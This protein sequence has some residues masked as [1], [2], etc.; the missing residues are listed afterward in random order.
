MAASSSADSNQIESR[1]EAGFEHSHSGI[2]DR[3]SAWDDVVNKLGIRKADLIKESKIDGGRRTYLFEGRVYKIV[4]L[5]LEETRQKRLLS[6][7][8]EQKI[9]EKLS[10][11]M[12]VPQNPVYKSGDCFECLIYDYIEG[13][14]LSEIKASFYRKL[15]LLK[16]IAAITAKF[17][18]KGIAHNDI[19]LSNILVD[20]SDCVSIVDFDQATEISAYIAW[21]VNFTGAGMGMRKSFGTV[22]SIIVELAKP[23]I[24]ENVPDPVIEILRKVM[25]S[26]NRFKQNKR[27]PSINQKAD[28]K[29][30][31][32]EE[33][34]TLSKKSDAN[35]PGM[36]ICY[37]ELWEGGYCFPGERPWSERWKTISSATDYK[38]KRVLELGCNLSLLSCFL[39]KEA[40]AKKALCVDGDTRI[41]AAAQFV[42]DAY[43]VA[44]LYKRV[45][46]DDS[47]DWESELVRYRPDVVFALSVLNWISDKQRFLRF[48]SRFKE[49][50]Y[51]GH[52]AKEIEE[53]RLVESGFS[54]VKL[55]SVSERG[56]FVFLCQK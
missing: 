15:S 52:E 2:Q 39:L 14:P 4:Q 25:R 24:K 20:A 7:E 26:F 28:S 46:F 8:G 12:G 45:R 34:W 40:G 33:A 32:L 55:L 44:P 9:L 6:L 42:A 37:Y 23:H 49:V 56:R 21:I 50:V 22:S 18:S 48:L 51:E 17:S 53:K 43:G 47:E 36:P 38:N 11:I 3:S 13:Q 10:G 27:M 16:K 35:S 19:I 1:I 29:L 41:L 5:Y 31:R 30:H 54:S